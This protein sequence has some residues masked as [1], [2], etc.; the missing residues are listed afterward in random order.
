[1]TPL[2][3]N[4]WIVVRHLLRVWRFGQIRFRLETFGLYYPAGQYERPV[5]KVSPLAL[6]LLA[7]RSPSYARWIIDMERLREGGS[8][9]WWHDHGGV[10]RD[11]WR[12][13][14]DD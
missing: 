7:R 10:P 3:R 12:G 1:M 9:S 4:L 8:T 2:L 6:L 5:W 13:Q 14:G 11:P